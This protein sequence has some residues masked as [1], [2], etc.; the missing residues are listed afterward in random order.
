MINL[1]PEFQR[2]MRNERP[3]SSLLIPLFTWASGKEANIEVCEVINKY[4]FR[5]DKEVLTNTLTLNNKLRHFI[6]Y[7]K[8]TKIDSKLE[9]FYKDLSKKFGWSR[10]ELNKNIHLLDLESL[11]E[12][13]ARDFG[14]DDKERKLLKLKKIISYLK[15][16]K[17]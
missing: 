15:K 12:E 3:D 11:K 14:Y 2:L 16:K 13:L 7:P 6:K 1:G 8:A 5:V 10:T 17:R 4:M 9:F